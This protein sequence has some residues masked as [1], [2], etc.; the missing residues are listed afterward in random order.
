MRT[1]LF[2]KGL[3]FAAAV[4]AM[5]SCSKENEKEKEPQ[6]PAVQEVEIAAGES[7]ELTFKAEADWKLTIDKT[8]WCM[9][10]DKG[11]ETAQVA[12]EAGEV[13]VKVKIGDAG[14]GFEAEVAKIDM[15][16]G[17]KT[18]TV[19]QITRSPKE[20]VVKMYVSTDWGSTY[21]KADKLELTS[22]EWGG[23]S[24]LAFGIV[25]NYEW[26]LAELPE[27][28]KMQVDYADVDSFSGKADSV[29]FKAAQLFIKEDKIP[30]E[31]SKKIKI[32]DMEG[33]NPVEFPVTYAGLAE[34]V[35]M[36]DPSNLVGQWSA[37][38]N[39]TDDGFFVQ[40]T[41]PW[42]PGTVTTEKSSSVSVKAKNMQ[43]S[44]YVVEVKDG[45]PA[46][47]TSGSWLKIN[48]DKKG[49][50]VFSVDNNTATA[51]R[52][53]YAFVLPASKN[54]V[55]SEHFDEWGNCTSQFGFKV[56]QSGHAVADDFM[57]QWGATMGNVPTVKFADYA[58]FSGMKPSDV[59][60]GSCVD[61]AYVAEI[62]E[63]SIVTTM[64]RPAGALKF[65]PKGLGE[66]YYPVSGTDK[67]Y[68]FEA[69]EGNWD[70]KNVESTS[71][72]VGASSI[73]GLS[74]NQAQFFND[75]GTNPVS[76]NFTGT[77][78]VHFYKTIA[79][80]NAGKAV[81]TLVI[82]KK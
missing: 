32:T 67:L 35:V 1:N 42:T 66:G 8:T 34:D 23:T 52:V 68:K 46:Q 62:S 18:Q 10:D 19:F 15:T 4:A 36:L 79:D 17:E 37:G 56:T 73:N 76:K 54:L 50:L 6:F 5:M 38:M 72:Y 58:G 64:G 25:A 78:F 16:M 80:K 3:A 27:E 39:F 82:V 14:L 40:K 13:T 12:G 7:K 51:D 77:V 2:T 49:K 41:D 71:L 70:E 75:P 61:N 26:K 21:N 28:L 11:V 53:A 44:V 65:A 69:Y 24:Y 48:D 63:T 20:R 45:T 31:F 9:F 55:I 47:V 30:Y 74:I 22:D 59:K 60:P 81:A 43:Y 57:V 33:N 29:D